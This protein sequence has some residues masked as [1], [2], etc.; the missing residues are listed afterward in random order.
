L[1]VP[2]NDAVVA[3]ILALLFQRLEQQGIEYCVL[4]AY[5][6]LPE[7]FHGDVDLLANAKDR[8]K[9]QSIVMEITT[10]RGWHLLKHVRKF[11]MWQLFFYPTRCDDQV[12]RFILQLDLYYRVS[13]KGVVLLS[14]EAILQERIRYHGFFIPS[15]H[16]ECAILL[17]KDLL[18]Q[19]CV[20]P[21]HRPK[22]QVLAE[23]HSDGTR[24]CL[25]P[26]VGQRMA[27][28]L[29]QRVMAGHWEEIEA[30]R[31]A[32]RR[33]IAWLTL[34]RVPFAQIRNWLE[35]LWGH[36]CRFMSTPSGLFIVVLGVDGSG[37]TT[38]IGDVMLLVEKF[39]TRSRRLAFNFHLLPHISDL[40][41][42]IHSKQR[43]GYPVVEMVGDGPVLTPYSTFR[44]LASLAYHTV[45]YLLGYLYLFVVRRLGYLIIMERYVYDYF[46]QPRYQRVPKWMLKDVQA[47]VPR[48]DAMIYLQGDP[49]LIHD[50]KPELSVKE[51][52]RQQAIFHGLLLRAS[53]GYTIDIGT[54]PQAVARQV[55]CTVCSIL[56]HRQAT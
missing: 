26:V 55:G 48:P 25:R 38:V 29:R 50:R 53:R 44:V 13:W 33:A 49:Q 6:Q 22:I 16:H 15:P 7:V 8:S 54:P 34:R 5:E 2:S 41:N 21:K 36:L 18:S 56:E 17:L 12:G 52:E 39:L 10:E 9:F 24:V 51:I 14:A 30:S 20:F 45:G 4:R 11:D 42:W 43:K 32:V 27:K 1:I 47:I 40:R 35:F 46:I 23:Q 19:G 28:F 37:K 31:N 3:D